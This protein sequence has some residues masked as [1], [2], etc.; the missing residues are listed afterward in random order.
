MPLEGLEHVLSILHFDVLRQKPRNYADLGEHGSIER[1]P[2]TA[3]WKWN[4]GKTWAR[5]AC[6]G[7]ALRPTRKENTGKNEFDL[8]ITRAL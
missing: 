8:W 1:R 5:T 3:S 4:A 2:K 6:R 7:A